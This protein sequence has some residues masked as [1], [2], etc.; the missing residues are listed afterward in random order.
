VTEPTSMNESA[1]VNA[2]TDRVPSRILTLTV[3]GVAHR[4]LVEDRTLLVH[5]LREHLRL[6]G[7]HIGCAN[8]DCGACTVTIDGTIAKSCLLLA[9]SVEGRAV[10]TI[11]GYHS[12]SGELDDLQQALWDHDAFQCGFCLPG[13]LFALADL[14]ERCPR[15]DEGDVRTALRG[16]LCRCTG[17]Q[18]L[19]DA[20]LATARARNV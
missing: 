9:V 11:E 1:P 8:G 12:G 18:P 4:V 6:T 3:N 15:P 14:L 10:T 13:H 16:N 19:V 2:V 5:L 20:A 7:T 17:Y